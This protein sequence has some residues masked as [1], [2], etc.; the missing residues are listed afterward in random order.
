M[1]S[2]LLYASESNVLG[3]ADSRTFIRLAPANIKIAL[4][5]GKHHKE[6]RL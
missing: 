2:S 1:D 3:A 6:M 5:L 4:K